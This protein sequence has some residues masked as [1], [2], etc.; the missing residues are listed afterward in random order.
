MW[1]S[2][3]YLAA[4]KCTCLTFQSLNISTLLKYSMRLWP[5]QTSKPGKLGVF[6]K[7]AKTIVFCSRFIMI[8]CDKFCFK[9]IKMIRMFLK[10]IIIIAYYFSCSVMSVRDLRS[11]LRS[12]LQRHN[13]SNN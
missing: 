10:N 5:Y 8:Y 7:V 4:S 6:A 11:F 2:L 9:R 3:I 13:A 12:F 1:P